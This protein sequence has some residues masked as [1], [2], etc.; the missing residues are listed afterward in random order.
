M[1][2]KPTLLCLLAA[3]VVLPAAEAQ[4]QSAKTLYDR[5][6]A[7]EREL[8]DGDAKP[9]VQQLRAAVA[10]Y[11]RIVRRFPASAYSDNALWQAGNLALL[12]FDDFGQ[13]ADRA[14][15]V[16]LLSLLRTEYPSSSLRARASAVIKERE[17]APPAVVH[18]APRPAAQVS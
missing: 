5:A 7:R 3:L 11:E 8:R 13:A 2:I 18:A 10:A 4:A 6:L 17:A 14:T 1:T 12:A 16:R 9:S 15:G